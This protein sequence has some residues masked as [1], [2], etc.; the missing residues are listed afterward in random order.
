[1]L[2]VAWTAPKLP[3]GD[4]K[5]VFLC[6]VCDA[7]FYPPLS[8]PNYHDPDVMDWGWHQ[9]HIQQG[10]GLV[11]ITETL[12]RIARPAG[13]R[14]LEIGCGYGFG[15]DYATHALAWQG[16][17]IDPSP[18]A[19]LGA[20]DLGLTIRDGYFPQ[21]DSD[22]ALWDVIAAT[23][24]IEHVERPADLLAALR[25]RLAPDGILLLTT[26]DGAA[27]DRA[28]P[29][30]ALVQ[31]L[32]PGIHM[33][34]QTERSLRRLFD[35]A[36][37]DGA[38]I[39]RDGLTLI[40]YIGAIDGA[41]IENGLAHRQRFRAYLA[42]RAIQ[43]PATSD[44]GLGF[45]GRAMFE[46]AI[47]LD[48][49]SCRNARGLL[50]PAIRARFGLDPD[51][52]IEIPPDFTALGLAALKDAMPLNLGMILYAEASRLR[53]DPALRPRA[54]AMFA[55]AGDAAAALHAALAKA[56]LNDGL[57]EE[58]VWRGAAEA[59]I[60]A[61]RV[62]APE[63]LERLASLH[64][65]GMT[66]TER[67]SIFWR[68]AIELTNQGAI[69]A[70]RQLIA[71]ED[72]TASLD[73]MPA[74]LQRDARIVLGQSAL[75]EGG[76][77]MQAI[78]MA[79][80]LGPDD[81][82]AADLLL[83]GFIRLVNQ[84]RYAELAPRIAAVSVVCEGRDD[85][86]GQDGRDALAIVIEHCADPAA[87]PALLRPLAI[88]QVRRDGIVL[89]AFCRL[90]NDSRYDEAAAVADSENIVS[91]A[92]A[93]DDAAGRDARLA[94]ALLDLA[95]GDPMDVPARLTGLEIDEQRRRDILVGAFSRLV[96]TMR[97]GDAKSFAEEQMIEM[98]VCNDEAGRDAAIGLA[99]LDLVIGDPVEA[100]RRIAGVDIDDERR[101]Q[102]TLGSF[103]TLVN[104]ARYDEAITLRSDAPIELWTAAPRDEDG[105]DASIALIAL[106]LAT[107]DPT[108]VPL[109]LDRLPNISDDARADA[110]A[111]ATLRLIHLG[112]L[113]EARPL[114]A[115][116]D[117]SLLDP[118]SRVD[119]V[120]TE[121]HFA[122]EDDDIS[123]LTAILEALDV[124]G[125]EPA[126][127]KALAV[128]GFV[129][130]VN[131]G[132]FAGA[133]RLRHRI[134]PDFVNY[135]KATTASLR[136]AGFALGVLD[137]QE[138]PQPYRAEAAF[139]AVR[140]GFAAELS[141]GESAPALFWESLRGEIIALHQTGRAA[142]ATA[143]GRAMLVRFQGAPDDLIQELT[144]G[145]H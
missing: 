123:A 93:R 32:A 36:G 11:P 2:D 117:L 143:L 90:V 38:V 86:A 91:R 136:S 37:F 100:P 108:E 72:L 8:V 19:R 63:T 96:N 85:A 81:P 118:A 29:D 103:V 115:A 111:Q 42:S 35:Q 95:T 145:L 142:E 21:A 44:L 83:G 74:D 16:M 48:W 113:D 107:G 30:A 124:D 14:F 105:A 92:V 4:R 112:R 41:L 66:D 65:L 94:L 60:E 141:E 109:L 62:A 26:P 128:R 69:D 130:A 23:E 13:T 139:A 137:L 61:A 120:A 47:D 129:T 53:A 134:E 116:T 77:P 39:T 110:R 132:D 54:G 73:D 7:R 17:G 70:A 55:L 119:L 1:M 97:Y 127:V 78:A 18:M 45:A 24:M 99:I 10:A 125:A 43:V 59:A 20:D 3:K 58:L 56:T 9:F 104:R 106:A 84:S 6:P 131:R 121:A 25:A 71:R 15:L 114:I 138:P 80:A 52:M 98:F 40:A 87:I 102:I 51:T 101:R 135:A 57:A 28:T 82:D 76:D 144:G 31:L 22:A 122:I 75:A 88:D 79:D 27:I 67:Q 46:A 89:E 34:F 140:R 50:W 133:A 49:P 5:P 68:G 33:V 126:R 64:R 12:G